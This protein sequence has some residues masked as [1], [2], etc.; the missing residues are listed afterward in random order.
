MPWVPS[1][2]LKTFTC[3]RH[4]GKVRPTR[5]AARLDRSIPCRRRAAH[6]QSG[7]FAMDSESDLFPGPL[8]RRTD[9][10][11]PDCRPAVGTGS[12][13]SLT[14]PTGSLGLGGK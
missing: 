9:S 4:V 2:T 11:C 10:S 7:E 13:T 3:R 12:T 1:R 8:V 5:S 6:W 14:F